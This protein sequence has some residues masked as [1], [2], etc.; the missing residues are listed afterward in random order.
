MKD[1]PEPS[2]VWIPSRFPT[3]EVRI[4]KLRIGGENPILIQSMT[5][6]DTCDTDAVVAEIRELVDNFGD[7]ASGSIDPVAAHEYPES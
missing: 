6:A 7:V 4:G 3:R 2:R 1:P 5:V